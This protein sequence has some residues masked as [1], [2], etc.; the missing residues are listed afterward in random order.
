MTRAN[1]GGPVRVLKFNHRMVLP[2]VSDTVPPPATAPAKT[3]TKPATDVIKEV[4]KSRNQAV[5]VPITT[6][7]KPIKMVKPKIVK[8]VIKVLH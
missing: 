4:P 2:L 1:D 5:P 3:D 6:P 8:P 7:I